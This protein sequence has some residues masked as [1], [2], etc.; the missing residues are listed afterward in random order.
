[1]NSI[2]FIK[3]LIPLIKVV[4]NN[5]AAGIFVF[6]SNNAFACIVHNALV[7]TRAIG[8]FLLTTGPQ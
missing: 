3:N 6:T 2:S 5:I 1:M 7:F 8:S 4:H